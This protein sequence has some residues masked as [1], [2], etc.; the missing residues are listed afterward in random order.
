M[1]DTRHIGDGFMATRD[2]LAP[3]GWLARFT[4]YVAC[5]GMLAAILVSAVSGLAQARRETSLASPTPTRTVDHRKHVFEDQRD[6]F[7]T[8]RTQ[9]TPA[10][11]EQQ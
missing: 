6:R 11:R 10:P 5:C 4:L 2:P 1:M 7:A 3:L 9:S 8:A